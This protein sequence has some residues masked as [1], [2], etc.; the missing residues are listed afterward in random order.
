VGVVDRGALRR[1]AAHRGAPRRIAHRAL[2]FKPGADT[3]LARVRHFCAEVAGARARDASDTLDSGAYRRVREASAEAAVGDNDRITQLIVIMELMASG[4]IPLGTR[5]GSEEATQLITNGIGEIKVDGMWK[6]RR[7]LDQE[8]LVLPLRQKRLIYARYLELCPPGTGFGYGQFVAHWQAHCAHVRRGRNV[9]NMGKCSLCEKYKEV[10]RHVSKYSVEELAEYMRQW[11]DVHLPAQALERKVFASHVALAMPRGGGVI[12]GS[13]ISL[14]IDGAGSQNAPLPSFAEGTSTKGFEEGKVK[15]KMMGVYVH[16]IGIYMLM[17]T[18]A[19][20]HGA[21][22]TIECIFYVLLDLQSRYGAGALPRKA[23]WQLD[24][25]TDNKCLGVIGFAM[26]LL[27]LGVFD[28]IELCFLLRGHTH[29]A[30]VR[31]NNRNS[32]RPA[33]TSS[34]TLTVLVLA[35]QARQT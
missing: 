10:L 13:V 6:E 34:M 1:T 18:D 20:A 35:A 8:L 26:W 15:Q 3:P 29:E 30:R 5:A 25:C 27:A 32:N 31:V 7:G 28:E 14:I 9:G 33:R 4:K 12:F 23:C 16:W 19:Q 21:N 2:P 11:F 22:L 24:N 17:A